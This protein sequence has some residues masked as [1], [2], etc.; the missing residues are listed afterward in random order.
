MG[1]I[2]K[3]THEYHSLILALLFVFFNL[4]VTVTML[5]IFKAFGLNQ[6]NL[7]RHHLETYLIVTTG[8]IVGLITVNFFWEPAGWMLVVLGVSRILQI[9]SINSMTLL[10]D[11]HLLDTSSIKDRDRARW[12]FVA[13]LF[14]IADILLLYGFFF[15]FFNR[16]YRIL[17]IPA[18]HFFD[19]FYYSM[20]TIMT[21][22]YGDIVPITPL[23]KFLALSE[24]FVGVFLFVFLVNAAVSRFQRH[25]E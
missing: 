3:K 24:I 5:I 4:V 8:L 1:S 19:H 10:F 17:S 2:Q 23:G 16:L 6:Q 18:E 21:V 14:S 9:I 25:L 20:M 22:G 15:Y 7:Q 13:I 12:H 11:F